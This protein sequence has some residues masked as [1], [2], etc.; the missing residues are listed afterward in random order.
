MVTRL[1][2]GLL[3]GALVLLTACSQT[4]QP[5]PTASVQEFNQASQN[6][7]KEWDKLLEELK[8]AL[9]EWRGSPSDFLGQSVTNAWAP[10]RWGEVR[11]L[12]S[13]QTFTTLSILPLQQQGPPLPRGEFSCPNDFPD[14][15]N[16][17]PQ[18]QSNNFSISWRDGVKLVVNWNSTAWA[19]W[20]QDPS[21]FQ[22]IPTQEIPT[23]A[24]GSLTKG[25]QRW[26]GVTYEARLAQSSCASGKYVLPWE[27]Q[28]LK[29]YLGTRYGSGRILQVDEARYDFGSSGFSTEGGVG[30]LIQGNDQKGRIEWKIQAN[31]QVKRGPCGE[32]EEFVPQ[33]GRVSISLM[34]HQHSARFGFEAT[35]IRDWDRPSSKITIENGYLTIDN[36]T[37]T[38][39][40]VL[41]DSNGNGIPGEN[42][43]VRFSDGTKTLEDILREQQQRS[44]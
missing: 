38:F 31:G 30:F 10:E 5:S 9:E 29:G 32:I 40:G 28:S 36:K 26:A 41:D 12:F 23:K 21:Q 24:E 35:E 4:P 43:E 39:K 20:P 15:S 19:H 37:V 6:L 25:N 2:L 34:V 14:T 16:C 11:D 33:S 1:V 3:V 22:E 42:L 18:A 13:P 17:S 44:Q 8:R 7:S 27:M